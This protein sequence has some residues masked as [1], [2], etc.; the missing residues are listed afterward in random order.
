MIEPHKYISYDEY[1]VINKFLALYRNKSIIV[2]DRY[3][4]EFSTVPL[5]NGNIILK[6]DE[7]V[8]KTMYFCRTIDYKGEQYV[9]ELE[10]SD[11]IH[12]NQKHQKINMFKISTNESVH[13][14]DQEFY[15]DIWSIFL[16]SQKCIISPEQLYRKKMYSNKALEKFLMNHEWENIEK[17]IQQKPTL[18]N[19]LFITGEEY[20]SSMYDIYFATVLYQLI[21]FRIRNLDGLIKDEKDLYELDKLIVRLRRAKLLK[22]HLSDQISGSKLYPKKS[23]LLDHYNENLR[24]H[25]VT[26]YNGTNNGLSAE[27]S[28]LKKLVKDMK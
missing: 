13:S 8:M 17:G 28:V 6:T 23:I 24:T 25:E 14:I 22:I 16:E 18:A 1:D 26:Q 4:K 3:T 11:V 5:K 12:F 7:E 9:V 2:A 19:S 20:G 21:D 27:K 15:S 10:I